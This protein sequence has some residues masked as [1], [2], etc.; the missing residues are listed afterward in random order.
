MTDPHHPP[1][2]RIALVREGEAPG[3]PAATMRSSHD[4]AHAFHFLRDRDREE[5]WVAAL[6]GK[7]R[8]IGTHC[9]SIGTLTAS[10]VHPREVVKVLVLTSAAACVLVH[11]HPSGDPTPSAEDHAITERLANVCALLGIAVLDH[12]I[13][14]TDRHFS[15]ADAGQLPG[16]ASR[17]RLD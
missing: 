14:G 15:F 13:V 2:W 4:V 16:S 7:N 3:F 5:F 10:L 11:V 9:V 12:V 17:P 1:R 6:D 8:L